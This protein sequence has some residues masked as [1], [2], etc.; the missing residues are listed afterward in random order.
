MEK[1]DCIHKVGLWC[2]EYGCFCG[3]YPGTG[4]DAC[5]TAF[6]EEEEDEQDD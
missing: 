4:L 6:G 1:R 3:E 2:A 5:E